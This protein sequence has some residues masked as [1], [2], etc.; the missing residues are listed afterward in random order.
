M[1]DIT[2]KLALYETAQEFFGFLIAERARNIFLAMHNPTISS[3]QI[4][5]WEEEQRRFFERA[6]ALSLEDEAGLEQVVA[7]LA[8]LVRASFGGEHN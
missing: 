6:D 8:P 4:Q 2:H 3:E 5:L 7:E 1:N